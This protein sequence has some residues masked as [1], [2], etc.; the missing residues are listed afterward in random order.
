MS[1]SVSLPTKLRWAVARRFLG[2]IFSI[3][4]C[5]STIKTACRVCDSNGCGSLITNLTFW[6]WAVHC[7]YFSSQIELPHHAHPAVREFHSLL[8]ALSLGLSFYV[9]V[10]VSVLFMYSPSFTQR[11]ADAEHLPVAIVWFFSILAHYVP[12]LLHV[13]GAHPAAAPAFPASQ[14]CRCLHSQGGAVHP[15]PTTPALLPPTLH[16]AR[17]RNSVGPGAGAYRVVPHLLHRSGVCRQ[18]SAC[19]HVFYRMR[20]AAH[21]ADCVCSA[22]PAHE[23]R[24]GAL[25]A[26]IRG[27]HTQRPQPAAAA[28]AHAH[29]TQRNIVSRNE[30]LNA[31][32]CRCCVYPIYNEHSC[33]LANKHHRH[34]CQ[35][36]L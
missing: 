7:L 34:H 3:Y 18:Y 32:Q 21:S 35:Q 14:S 9:A 33:D 23:R 24:C 26:Q 1:S 30:R 4:F 10:A 31:A 8:H 19:S 16:S 5:V 17:M 6:A 25:A 22:T 27:R 36:W 11:H 28:A 15:L 20:G 29:I 2:L 12:P 13:T